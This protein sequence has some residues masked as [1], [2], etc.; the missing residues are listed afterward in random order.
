M[1]TTEAILLEREDVNLENGVISIKR[2]KGYDQHFVVLHDT[3]L[4]LMRIYD[5]KISELILTAESFSQRQMTNRTILL[6]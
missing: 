3:M 2:G 1:R 6:G 5:G 4:S